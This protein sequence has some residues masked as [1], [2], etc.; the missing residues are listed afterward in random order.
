[1]RIVAGKQGRKGMS[2]RIDVAE[3][4]RVERWGS[5]LASR[6]TCARGGEATAHDGFVCHGEG[7]EGGGFFYGN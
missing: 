2:V 4:R 5:S 1:M 3:Q 6:I 7:T